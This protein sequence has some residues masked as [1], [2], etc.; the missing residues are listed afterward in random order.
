MKI[1]SHFSSQITKKILLFD[2]LKIEFK[3]LRRPLKIF[4]YF[5]EKIEK[6]CKNIGHVARNMIKYAYERHKFSDWQQY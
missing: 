2:F 6:N 4:V 1:L 5:N 3:I